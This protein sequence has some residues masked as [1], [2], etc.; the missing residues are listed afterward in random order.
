M[1][2]IEDCK[3]INLPRML[4]PRGSL[5]FIEQMESIPFEIE[6]VFYIYD[7]PTAESR[8]AHSHRKLHQFLIPLSGSFDVLVDDGF[9]ESS[10]HLNRPWQ[11]LHIPPGIW[12]SEKNFDPGQFV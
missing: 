3:V 7:V 9:N 5:T 1:A 12:A 2:T 4:D 6:R 11:G 10:F 8:G